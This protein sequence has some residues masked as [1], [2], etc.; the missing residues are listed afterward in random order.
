MALLCIVWAIT[1]RIVHR[2]SWRR[3]WS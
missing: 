2:A 1:Y 3:R